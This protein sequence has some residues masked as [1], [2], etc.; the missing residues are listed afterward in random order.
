MIVKTITLYDDYIRDL[1]NTGIIKHIQEKKKISSVNFS[2][3]VPYSVYSKRALELFEPLVK[4]VSIKA[5][6]LEDNPQTGVLQIYDYE[7]KGQR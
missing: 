4:N 1:L 5:K 7:R 6:W 2:G 3:E